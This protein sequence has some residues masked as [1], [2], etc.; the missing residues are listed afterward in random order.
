MYT[1]RASQPVIAA[2]NSI[3]QEAG[4][5]FAVEVRR[6]V[7]YRGRR[8]WDGNVGNGPAAEGH[9]AQE[10]PLSVCAQVQSHGVGGCTAEIQSQGTRLAAAT[11]GIAFRAVIES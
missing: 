11:A 4:A 1:P 7:E 5:G 9:F 8:D 2:D 6:R 10:E 3:G